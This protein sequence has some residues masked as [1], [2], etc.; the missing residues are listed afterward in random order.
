L[1]GIAK[2]SEL[3]GAQVLCVGFPDERMRVAVRVPG[4]GEV[5]SVKTANVEVVKRAPRSQG[6][7]GR[8]GGPNGGGCGEGACAEGDCAKGGCAKGDCAGGGCDGA[9]ADGTC[10]LPKRGMEESPPGDCCGGGSDC[11]GGNAADR[12][13]SNAKAARSA[14][15]AAGAPPSP[16]GAHDQLQRAWE[17]PPDPPRHRHGHSTRP[18]GD[19]HQRPASVKVPSVRVEAMDREH[20]LCA[21]ALDRLAA[22]RS[23]AAARAV[24]EAYRAH[25]AHEEALLDEHVYKQ[26]AREA[27]WAAG[28]TGG[29][30]GASGVGGAGAAGG[31]SAD[32]GARKSHWADHARLLAGVEAL[33]DGCASGGGSGGAVIDAAAVSA[34]AADFERHA[35]LYDGA[36]ADRLSA[37][38]VA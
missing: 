27:Q 11:G 14:E 30:G 24:V 13:I 4:S 26:A 7:G 31:F 1:S 5:I 16:S 33:C 25:F 36:Y 32:A 19:H 38:L 8:C 3:N 6:V 20:A 35:R 21:E 10:A 9:R 34:V 22:D 28:A 18:G 17:D 29:G 12:E 37:A 2:R 23:A 15:G